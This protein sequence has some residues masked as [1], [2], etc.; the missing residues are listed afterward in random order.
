MDGASAGV[1]VAIS[2]NILVTI[3]GAG[4]L[5]QKVNDLMN[6]ISH[7]EKRFDKADSCVDELSR[8]VARIEGMMEV[9]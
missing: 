9:K 6:H 5:Y 2:V 4:R 7:L 8:K 1:I 3:F